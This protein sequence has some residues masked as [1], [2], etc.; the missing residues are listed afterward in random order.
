ML[1]QATRY[2]GLKA[3]VALRKGISVHGKLLGGMNREYNNSFN[4]RSNPL[5][6]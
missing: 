4:K 1:N 6:G 5:R 3:R 2:Q